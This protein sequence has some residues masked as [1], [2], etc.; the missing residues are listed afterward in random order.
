M[1]NPLNLY[2]I[3]KFIRGLATPFEKWDA[4]KYGVI[5][6]KG[7]ILIKKKERRTEN[8]RNSLTV[9]DTLVLNM[10]KTLSKI[11]GGNSLFGSYAAAL[12]LI[13]ESNVFEH[14]DLIME[15]DEI[16]DLVND[17]VLSEE[18][19]TNNVGSGNIAGLGVGADGEAPMTKKK[20]KLKDFREKENENNKN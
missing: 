11:P 19:P 12:F 13:R 9:F 1:A 18:I 16:H 2:L 5:D 15:E 10:K 14:N 7:N 20:K 6:R 17:F 8:E 4:Y 3:Y